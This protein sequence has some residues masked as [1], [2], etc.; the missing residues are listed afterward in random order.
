MISV[1]HRAYR[2]IDLKAIE[3]NFDII[4]GLIDK[5]T[6]KCAVIKADAY[7]HGAVKVAT[8]L[9]DK[10]DYFA[11]A[12]IGEALEIRNAGITLPILV[13]AYTS[14]LCF[15]DLIDYG[16]T[17]TVYTYEDALILNEKAKEMGKEAKIHIAVD[18]GMS[19]IGF[20]YSDESAEIIKKITDLPYIF[21]EGIFSHFAKADFKDKT[22]ALAQRDIF[23][24]FLR[25]LSEKGADIPVKH[26]YNSAAVVSFGS[27]YDM[28]RM[29]IV[30]YGINPFDHETEIPDLKPAMTVKTHVIHLHT[31]EEGTGVSYGH[32]YVADKK[33]TIAT[34]SMGYADG[35]KRRL[36]NK[37]YFL[38]N[39]KKAPITGRVCMDIVMVDVTDIED[40]RI[41]DEAILVG[42]SGEREISAEEY[43]KMY[44]SF[45]YEVLSTFMP[46][47]RKIYK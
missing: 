27:R 6:K 9:K 8:L 2:E 17:A 28:V 39:G 45:A 23:D 13:L 29:G 19:R 35:L 20:D 30:L 33:R 18:T 4:S 32:L 34:L 47:V 31:V 26:L 16:I 42:K 43:G 40:V 14:P 11:V 21:T 22:H 25:K 10:A 37:G 7:G 24:A 36:S 46:R 44:G 12:S 3:H 5:G 41:G 15:G 1:Y 38:I